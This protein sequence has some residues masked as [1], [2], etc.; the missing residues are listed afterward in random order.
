MTYFGSGRRQPSRRNR[1]SRSARAT[2]IA[3]KVRCPNP[4]FRR[5]ARRIHRAARAGI[6]LQAKSPA[7]GIP[8]RATD[9]LSNGLAISHLNVA[10][11]NRADRHAFHLPAVPWCGLVLAVQFIA[12]DHTL[13]VHV[14][15]GNVAI[16]AE[17]NGSLLWI[18]LPDLCRIF[19]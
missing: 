1:E 3:Q 5:T 17:P 16:G 4:W 9:W 13:F 19:T 15:D 10:A 14:D 18:E 7:D 6:A 11:D 8:G 2:P 12:V